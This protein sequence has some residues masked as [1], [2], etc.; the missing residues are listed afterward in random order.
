MDKDQ[1][2]RTIKAEICSIYPSATVILYGSR[3]R[4]DYSKYS[5][6]DLLILLEDSINDDER[7]ALID[8]LY[9]LELEIDQVFSPIIHNIAEWKELEE[10]PFYQNVVREGKAI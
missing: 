6:W 10:T 1:V 5:D 9:D 3:I 2:L 8:R 7:T 4:G